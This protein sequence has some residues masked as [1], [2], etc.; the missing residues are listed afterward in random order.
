MDLWR[1]SY[2]V[3]GYDPCLFHLLSSDFDFVVLLNALRA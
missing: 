2:M 1:V 3:R